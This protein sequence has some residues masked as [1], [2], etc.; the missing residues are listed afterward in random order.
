MITVYQSR[1]KQILQYIQQTQSEAILLMVP[2]NIYYFTGF[3]SEPHERFFALYIEGQTEKTTLFVPSLDMDA[4]KAKAEVDEII[5]VSD[6]ENPYEIFTQSIGKVPVRFALEKSYM[7]ISQVEQFKQQI[8]TFS[9]E[10]IETYIWQMRAN[11]TENE[12]DKIKQA[13]TIS[14]QALQRTWSKIKI[15]MT[16]LEVKAELEYQMTVLG[17]DAIAFETIVL[18]GKRAA[19]PHGSAS[20][21]K[22]ENGNF[23]LFDFGVT[24]DGYHSDLTRTCIV[25]EGTEEQ[26]KIYETVRQANERAIQAVKTGTMLQAIDKAGR[27]FIEAQGYGE[28]FTH[29]IGHG[30][31]LDVHEYPSIH[32][33]NEEY[34]QE[35]LLFTVEPGIYVPEIGGVRIEDDIYI[36]SSGEVEVLSSF[37]KELIY[38]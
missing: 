11:K 29:R 22:I 23:L 14:E 15:G 27:M 5:S 2:N 38:V 32:S 19:L 16:E 37:S 33:N 12:I 13:I 3:L 9:Y 8:P 34:I 18:S 25:G 36:T 10:N 21:T 4:A 35:G 7:T 31:G 24:K 26:R 6:I 17:A 30:L 20:D 1:Q 28:Y